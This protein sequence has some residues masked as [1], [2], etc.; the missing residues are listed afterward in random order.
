MGEVMAD[1]IGLLF[2]FSQ[3]DTHLAK[4]FLGIENDTYRVGGRLENYVANGQDISDVFMYANRC[5]E[6]FK[7]NLVN[8]D[9]TNPFEIL[10]LYEKE[11][12]GLE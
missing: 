9:L 4:V 2:A 3:Y 8:L 10:N 5:V 6:V 12:I 1:M 11:K 7:D